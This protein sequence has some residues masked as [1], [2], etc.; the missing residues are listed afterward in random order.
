MAS[1][2]FAD[3]QPIADAIADVRSDTT[4]TDWLLCGYAQGKVETLTLVGS[5][6]G[7]TDEL[8]NHLKEDQAM[9]G[10]VR[11]AER[12]DESDTSMLIVLL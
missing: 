1:K 7:G 5:G 9:Y 10:L 11:I 2:L 8:K 4:E 3:W 12:I 6:V